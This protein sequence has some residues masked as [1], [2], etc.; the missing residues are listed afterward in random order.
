[1]ALITLLDASLAY[2]HVALLDHADFA[3][4]PSERIGLI[5]R[6]GTGKSSFLKILA[7]MAHADDG[8]LHV[9]QGLRIAYVAQEPLLETEDTI[10]ESVQRG[11]APVM[12]LI[13]DYSNCIGDLDTLQSQIESL[14]GWGWAQRVD[15]TL[16]RLHLDPS[17]K[18]GTLSGGNRKRVALAQALVTQPDVLL[19]D[20]PTNHLD[21]DSIAWLEQLLLDFKGSVVAITHDRAFLDRI[22][23]CIVELDRGRLRSF[24]GN[25]AQY[26][27]NKE[28]QLAQEAVISAK[29]DK[30]LAQ[31]EVWIRKGV[32]A[33]RTRSQSRIA[34]L[35]NLRAT[36]SARREQVG[37]V[38]ME[39]ASGA[40]SGKL[41]AEL[42][43]V[44]KSFTSAD[45]DVKVIVKDFTATLLRGDKIGLL[46]PN[47]AGKTTLLKMILGELQA[48]SG[49]I[50]QGANLQ[51]AYF[52]QMRN[53]LDLEATLEDF[54][55]PGS[56]W[57]EIGNKRQHVK[58]YLGDFL[59]SPA[60]ANSP[61]KSLSGGERNRLLL[62]R[63][64]ARPANVLVLDEPTNDL[65]IDTLELLEELL[66][67]YEGTVFL[68]SH[69]RSFM[70]NVVTSIIACEA[71]DAH[72]GFWREYE[73]SV[74]DWLTQSQR[75]QAIQAQNKA[76]AVKLAG[77]PQGTSSATA[78]A[79]APTAATPPV[80]KSTTKLSYKEQ[81]EL[82]SLPGL[83]ES[84]ENEQKQ[85][86][87]T[88]EDSS[89]FA[90]D[91]AKATALYARDAEI[92]TALMAALERWETLAVK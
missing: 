77:T 82:D 89:L 39:V 65:D 80:E 56:E 58:S 86:R 54:I 46:G 78:K 19:L 44:C 27:I 3:L 45:G 51:V 81:R 43:D 30:L 88:L 24:P 85:I 91:P 35:E 79:P 75:S 6:N 71:S 53:A 83:I 2:G 70:D 74:Q 18:I 7:G 29:A 33:R 64:F 16:H 28:E 20:E 62:A 84:L 52:D 49:N 26:Q 57:I 17:A 90:T 12:K 5:G 10:F 59:F 63:L 55:S 68:V 14:D 32:E 38:R 21:L 34:R 47:G 22:A 42:T 9:Q 11:L 40:P 8:N 87:L 4:E 66:Q 13:D 73:G 92:D 25:F 61:V 15:E 67:T 1:M 60:R 37:R 31:E 23:T 72:P 50:R 41:V 69:D 76:A 48:D 36:R